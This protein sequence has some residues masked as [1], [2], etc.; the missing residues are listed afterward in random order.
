[1][2]FVVEID[3]FDVRVSRWVLLKLKDWLSCNSEKITLLNMMRILNAMF[4]LNEII[5]DSKIDFSISIA[6]MLIALIIVF[7]IA[8][9]W[10]VL[11]ENEFRDILAFS[12]FLDAFVE[13]NV[14][15]E[16]L[17]CDFENR[18]LDF[19]I[20]FWFKLVYDFEHIDLNHRSVNFWDIVREEIDYDV[21]LSH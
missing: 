11:I 17:N 18:I 6:T 1:M 14:L 16:L 20:F 9:F 7:R 5:W 4:S 21:A 12:F 15:N 13:Y 3:R 19:V 8:F 10:N 2:F